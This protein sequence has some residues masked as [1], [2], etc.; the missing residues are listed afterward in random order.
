MGDGKNGGLKKHAAEISARGGKESAR[1]RERERERESKAVPGFLVSCTSEA[2]TDW[3]RTQG[4]RK[5]QTPSR[6]RGVPPD[7]RNYY[8]RSKGT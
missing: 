8:E 6:S 7:P 4:R 5:V 1:E 3:L 2:G